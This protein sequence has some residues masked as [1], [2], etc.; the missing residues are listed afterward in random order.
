MAGS[1]PTIHDILRAIFGDSADY[2]SIHVTN[3]A[4]DPHD[5]SDARWHGF[6]ASPDWS[7]PP[8]H[9]SF[10]CMGL[11]DPDKPGRSL[12]HVAAHVAFWMDDVGTKVPQARVDEWIVRTGLWPTLVIETSPGNHSV[13]WALQAPVLA[14]GSYDD[15]I[16]AAVR[17]K[18]KLDGWGDPVTQEP[19]R[20]MRTG[21]GIN[22]K[23]K[24]AGPDG[25]PWQVR[26]KA[27]LPDAKVSLFEF[28]E[29]MLGPDWQTI[30]QS[31]TYLTSRQ[32]VAQGGL[33]ASERRATMDMPLVRL[34]AE[35]GLD[36]QPST[37]AGVIDCRCPNEAAHTGGDPTGYAIINDGMSYCN[38]AS[39]QHLRSPDFQSLMIERFEDIQ[40]ER[41]ARGEIVPVRHGS[42]WMDAATGEVVQLTGAGF[43]AVAR[44]PTET[45]D[46]ERAIAEASQAAEHKEELVLAR[47]EG[48]DALSA[49][50]LYVEAP[51][52]FWDRVKGELISPARLDKDK[53]VLKHFKLVGGNNRAHVQLLNS[54]KIQHVDTIV[55]L[56]YRPDRPPASDIVEVIGVNGGLVKAVNTY[57]PTHIGFRPG[58]PQAYLDHLAFLF[59]GEPETQQYLL[60]YMAFRI[61]NPEVKATVIPI[62]G[63]APG[64]G[65]DVQL[66]QPFFKLLGLHNV[67][68]EM[69]TTKLVGG[70]ND[71]L[72]FPTIYMGEFNLGGPDGEKAYDRLK[73]LT[74]PN[75]VPATI[76]PKYGKT[77]RT[78]VSPNFIATT[79]DEGSLE[80]VPH[81]D[82]R[83]MVA[84]SQAQRL[85]GPGHGSGPGTDEYY[86]RLTR[87]YDDR[88]DAGRRNLEVLH[89]YLMN[90]PITLFH[91]QKAPPRTEAR[92]ETLVASLP[93]VARFVYE[94]VVEGDLSRRTVFAFAEIEARCLAAENPVVRTRVSHKGIAAG[95]RAAGCKS[96]GRVRMGGGKRVQ[97]WAGSCVVMGDGTHTA[98]AL[99]PEAQQL[100]VEDLD[101]AMTAFLAA[102]G[103]SA[104]TATA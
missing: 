47:E 73:D 58:K 11:L 38:H 4:G 25:A 22:G 26:I 16:V 87:A 2:K 93:S 69:T 9:N 66:L 50:F 1:G 57:R 91:P 79:N 3:F 84:W 37:R 61:Q 97:L 88:T 75:A 71:F 99:I 18:M 104:H 64:V 34:A 30:V 68:G 10:M 77:F 85:H 14:D 41:V 92:H 56:P 59:P 76:N 45:V 102:A 83:F 36:P 46:I 23:A 78:Y 19:A 15:Q 96:I 43:L 103:P 51:E 100:L 53:D 40:R 55:S 70:F 7:P 35:I 74:S 17:H 67:S 24:Y 13:F 31:D 5:K 52:M 39:C 20:Y 8:D 60:E 42:G 81:N 65:K 21:F 62:I 49:R 54:G 12:A 101:L 44:F 95:L 48:R 28:A 63:G 98:G 82:R 6:R 72:Q 89:H 80:H 29:A 27:F 33:G 32:L 90:L 94:L 86:D